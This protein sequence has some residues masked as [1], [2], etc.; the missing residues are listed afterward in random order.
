MADG[1]MGAME[2]YERDAFTAVSASA[3]VS[4]VLPRYDRVRQ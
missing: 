1:L 4:V 2:R 3:A